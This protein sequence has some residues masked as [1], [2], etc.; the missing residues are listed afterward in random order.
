MSI[1]ESNT[2]LNGIEHELETDQAKVMNDQAV[3]EALIPEPSQT[4]IANYQAAPA[5]VRPQVVEAIDT[6]PVM[7]EATP[8]AT[9]YKVERRHNDWRT[10]PGRLGRAVI[11]EIMSKSKLSQRGL[12]AEFHRIWPN[13]QAYFAYPLNES[14]VYGRWW[15]GIA[16][17]YEN[18]HV[19]KNA[20]TKKY[21]AFAKAIVDRNISI[22][23]ED[24]QCITDAA[25][26]PEPEEELEGEAIGFVP[27]SD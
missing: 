7:A 10:G 23:D 9:R 17:G 15:T 19:D 13:A 21:L 27:S 8:P 26:N 25:K 3:K 22:T 14:Q 16:R 1:D 4:A 12:F 24:V 5:T 6:P 11:H 18:E 20:E 2:A